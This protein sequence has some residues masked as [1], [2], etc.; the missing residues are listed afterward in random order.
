MLFQD[1]VNQQMLDQERAKLGLQHELVA[2]LN[3]E[4]I[5]LKRKKHAAEG[6]L[7]E[8]EALAKEHPEEVGVAD[9]QR[10]KAALPKLAAHCAELETRIHIAK[11]VIVGIEAGIQRFDLKKLERLQRIQEL[12][13]QIAG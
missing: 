10:A 8:I 2:N 6:I 11:R 9:Q 12:F 1:G 3:A 13:R 5:G 4:L 7:E